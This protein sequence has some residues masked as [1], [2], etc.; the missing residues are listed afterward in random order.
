[1]APKSLQ[2]FPGSLSLTY[3][4]WCHS[5]LALQP[6]SDT[7]VP[8]VSV[9]KLL[10]Q[11]NQDYSKT[12]LLSFTQHLSHL[13]LSLAHQHPPRW[14]GILFSHTLGRLLWQLHCTLP[15]WYQNTVLSVLMHTPDRLYLAPPNVS[16][17]SVHHVSCC[18]ATLTGYG[19]AAAYIGYAAIQ[20]QGA[21][22]VQTKWEHNI[23][24]YT[25][26]Q[27]V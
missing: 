18:S 25:Q 27:Q 24:H 11:S 7:M 17:R 19:N 14:L 4:W 2:C 20:L 21:K 16:W 10:W 12:P 22:S 13:L 5:G 9:S 23:A 6:L 8:Q 3:L 15:H 1:M 26:W